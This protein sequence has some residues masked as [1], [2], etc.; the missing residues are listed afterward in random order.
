MAQFGEIFRTLV[1]TNL[2]D[3]YRFII[4]FGPKLALSVII[5]ATGWVCA[6]LL[7]K[8]TSK[9]L[10]GLGCDVLSE[11]TGLKRFLEKGGVAKSLSSIIGLVFYW[12]II[13][14]TL[15]MVFNTLEMGEASLLIQQTFSYIPIAVVAI[16]L[17]AL[18][19]YLSR[20]ISR[21]VATSARLAQI[22]LHEMLGK[23]AQ[24]V[25]IGLTIMIVLEYLGL[26]VT[27][28]LQYAVIIFVVVPLIVS[29]IFLIG[30]RDI[31]ANILAGRFLAKEY[32]LGDTIEF[33]S[34]YGSVESVDI[35]TTK[36]KA[37]NEEIAVPNAELIARIIKR[38]RPKK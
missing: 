34:V 30:G 6:V 22:R 33:D 1:V 17:L 15:V 20:F 38:H 37:R 27:M 36:I 26:P 19:V 5:L 16:I 35:V 12:L 25:V 10:K 3:A 24:Y 2:E 31:V 29:L 11:K 14:S 4:E 8:I 7:K 23:I 18:G 28:M 21:F 32:E 13:F 9:L